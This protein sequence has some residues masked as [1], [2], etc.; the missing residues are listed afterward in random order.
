MD[1]KLSPILLSLLGLAWM[2]G[3]TYLYFASW[4]SEIEYDRKMAMIERGAVKPHLLCRCD[5]S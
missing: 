5:P 3:W 1:N 2:A 4:A